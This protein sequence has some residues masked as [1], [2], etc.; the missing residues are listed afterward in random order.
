MP[1]VRR[2]LEDHVEVERRQWRAAQ[3]RRRRPDHQELDLVAEEHLEELTEL[4]ASDH[5]AAP[6]D[7]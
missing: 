5:R 7:R 1:A 2:R 4:L 3:D 6:E